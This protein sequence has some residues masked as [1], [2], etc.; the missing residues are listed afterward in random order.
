MVSS[1]TAF[2]RASGEGEWGRAVWELRTVNHRYLEIM[3]RMPEE[4]RS[5]EVTARER[6]SRRV[7]R[8]KIECA[9]RIESTAGASADNPLLVINEE[10]LRQ[11]NVCL[12]RVAQSVPDLAPA[13]AIDVLRW[14]GMLAAAGCND[15]EIAPP[16]L[17]ILEDAI[18]ILVQTRQRE[19]AKLK[20][21]IKDKCTAA[22]RY[23][24]QL[25]LKVPLILDGLRD[26]LTNRIGELGVDV[27]ENRLEQEIV[28]Y[29][30]KM[31]VTEEI[32][33]LRTHTA[34]VAR[35]LETEEP[36]GRRLDFLMQEMN[37]EANTIASKSIHKDT[38][39]L[40]V[41]LKVLIEQMREQI[42]NV[43]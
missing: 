23:V 2:A 6:I 43:E 29:A 10:L 4:L 16:L 24:E 8:G 34:E 22:N 18:D 14:P 37:R 21:L 9:L 39:D 25:R 13:N 35:V 32:D 3:T 31:D 17:A 5:L 20:T 7:S 38:T 26:R 15:E 12:E 30:Q 36:I 33:R 19:G 40:S 1:M 11:L 28:F 42:Q 27:D 41:E